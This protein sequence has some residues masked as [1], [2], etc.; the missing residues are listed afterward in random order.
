MWSPV[1]VNS[2]R[3]REHGALLEDQAKQ[4]DRGR[5]RDDWA[6]GASPYLDASDVA[7]FVV[8]EAAVTF[9]GLC[10]ECQSKRT[11]GERA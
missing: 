7:S 4:L 10:P 6:I 3:T 9:W 2:H 5:V 11:E 8:D 1:E